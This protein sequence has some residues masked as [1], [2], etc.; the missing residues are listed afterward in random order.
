ML[1]QC[2]VSISLQ[3]PAKESQSG[4]ASSESIPIPKSN[5]RRIR[6]ISDSDDQVS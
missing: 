2:D 5:N 4:I 3:S 1:Q 6:L